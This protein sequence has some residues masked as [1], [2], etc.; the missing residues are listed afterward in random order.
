MDFDHALTLIDERSAALRDAVAAAAVSDARVPGCPEWDLRDLVAHLGAVQ[1]FWAAV[2]KA[3]DPTGRPP[4]EA[5]GDQE[6]RGDLLQWSAESTSMLLEAL[7][8]A[9]AETPAWAW[10]GASSSPLTV[11]AVA[12]HQVQ[13]AA[14]H[15]RDAQETIGRP[16]PLPAPVAVDGVAEFL[17]VGLGSLGPWPHRP[18]RVAFDA[19]DGPTS[20]AD[21]T[22]AGVQLDPAAAGDPVT[23]VRGP[24]SDLVLALYGR[25]PFDDLH[26]D[27]DREVL[28]QLRAWASAF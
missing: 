14:V 4:Q 10:W 12:R 23:T 25:V 5:V 6:P 11:G 22:P 15:A 17:Q 2:V 26:V 13:E 28:T 7:R 18:A 9:T 19:V 20:V 24:A 3:A 27:G 1:R 21:L 8:S 16:E